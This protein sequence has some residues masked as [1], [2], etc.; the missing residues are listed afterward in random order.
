MT[1]INIYEKEQ[2]VLRFDQQE[3]KLMIEINSGG[4]TT[5][6]VTLFLDG[7]DLDELLNVLQSIKE[8]Y[9]TKGV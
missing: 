3:K 1:W 7:A 9:F 8:Q 6:Y 2:I 5:K 4:L